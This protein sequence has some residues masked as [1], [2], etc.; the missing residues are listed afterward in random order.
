MTTLAPSTYSNAL[1]A[2]P[3]HVSFKQQDGENALPSVP[4]LT[5]LQYLETLNGAY[6]FHSPPVKF[7]IPF[8]LVCLARSEPSSTSST[9]H[10]LTQPIGPTQPKADI[11]SGKHHCCPTFPLHVPGSGGCL[12]LAVVYVSAANTLPA[13]APGP[14]SI[15]AGTDSPVNSS[16]TGLSDHRSTETLAGS[17]ASECSSYSTPTA[18]AATDAAGNGVVSGHPGVS[19]DAGDLAGSRSQSGATVISEERRAGGRSGTG[20]VGERRRTGSE[21]DLPSKQS[22]TS[23]LPD[24]KRANANGAGSTVQVSS[25]RFQTAPC[26]HPPRS[27]DA[28][29]FGHR[30]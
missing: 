27:R 5:T 19:G 23:V 29:K 30:R 24:K 10:S 14:I 28:G 18:S 25:K 8:E 6:A 20:E 3:P 12:C 2:T 1:P 22:E 21:G 26:A 11:A 15:P 7:L 16:A 9:E 4:V 13:P 17:G